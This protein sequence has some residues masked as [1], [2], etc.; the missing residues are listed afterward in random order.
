MV[1]FVKLGM[2]TAELRDACDAIDKRAVEVKQDMV[3]GAFQDLLAGDTAGRDR[4]CARANDVDDVRRR[5]MIEAGLR[6]SEKY[7]F[8]RD[9]VEQLLNERLGMN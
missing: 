6:I 9:T 3:A 8:D 4:G 2:M 5:A 1:D 7:G